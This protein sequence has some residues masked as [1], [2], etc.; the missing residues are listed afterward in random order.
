MNNNTCAPL[1]SVGLPI[2]NAEKHLEQA[3]DTILG[4]TLKN[5][6]VVISDNR[7]TDSSLSICES[8]ARKDNR[9][10]IFVQDENI[11]ASRNWNFVFENSTGRYFKWASA[12]DYVAEDMLETCITLL[13]RDPSIVLAYGRTMMLGNHPDDCEQ[14]QYDFDLME[15]DPVTR[16]FNL[17]WKIHYNNPQLGV[18]RRAAL[19]K[20]RLDKVYRSR[21]LVLMGERALLWKFRLLD[22]IQMWQ[23]MGDGFC[24]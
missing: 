17:C 19:E 12:N 23:R 21:E 18:I 6:E 22:K 4:Q 24:S 8:Y 11:G 20:T 5:I 7:S 13:E 10:R 14:Y 2:Y 16:F 9:I 15:D 3:L 1:C